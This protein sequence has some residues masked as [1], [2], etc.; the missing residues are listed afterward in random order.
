MTGRKSLTGR[1]FGSNEGFFSDSCNDSWSY[2]SSDRAYWGVCEFMGGWAFEVS[3]DYGTVS[4]QIGMNRCDEA[5]EKA[6]EVLAYYWPDGMKVCERDDKLASA[7][8]KDAARGEPFLLHIPVTD[9]ELRV[10]RKVS[11]I[12][13][14]Q[15]RTYGQIAGYMNRPNAARAVAGALAKNPVALAIPCHRV[16]PSTG[17][18]GGYRWG[19]DLKARLIAAEKES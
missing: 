18:T 3:D 11:F 2:S 9:F 8:V 19:E 10:Y 15:T 1:I 5:V 12:P 6:A 4:L 16:V 17:G 7:L 14:G 13:R